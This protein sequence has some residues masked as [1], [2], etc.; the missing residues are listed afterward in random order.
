MQ[1]FLGLIV[2]LAAVSLPIFAALGAFLYASESMGWAFHNYPKS[3]AL[4]CALLAAAV[5]IAALSFN[6]VFPGCGF[7][8]RNLRLIGCDRPAPHHT[9]GYAR[10]RPRWVNADRASGRTG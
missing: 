4:V 7:N 10:P 2:I 5:F 8:G 9:G 6:R 1:G 3:A